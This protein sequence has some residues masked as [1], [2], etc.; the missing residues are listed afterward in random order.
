MADKKTQNIKRKRKVRSK[1]QDD[2]SLEDVLALGGDKV[3]DICSL[4]VAR[5]NILTTPE[6]KILYL[7]ALYVPGILSL[8]F[9][10]FYMCQDDFEM[11]K[12]LDVSG[13]YVAGE[14][15]SG[16]IETKEVTEECLS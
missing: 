6:L 4:E 3:R 11:I 12:D 14:E 5:C 10:F 1:N 8:Y 16:I 9:I 15:N 7:V 2:F 13:D